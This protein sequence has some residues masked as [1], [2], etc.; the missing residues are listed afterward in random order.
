MCMYVYH[1]PISDFYS[2]IMTSTGLYRCMCKCECV[3]ELSKKASLKQNF[4]V[5]LRQHNMTESYSSTAPLSFHPLGFVRSPDILH[6]GLT[7]KCIRSAY[8]YI[9]ICSI[10]TIHSYEGRFEGRADHSRED[11]DN[12]LQLRSLHMYRFLYIYIHVHIEISKK[13]YAQ[14]L[15]THICCIYR[16]CC[17][18]QSY[19]VHTQQTCWNTYTRFTWRRVGKRVKLCLL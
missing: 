19:H 17:C 9:C 14:I 8:T 16:C 6:G 7:H 12:I 11:L 18:T 15:A 10:H 5:V 4:I 1:W 2:G 3:G 13:P